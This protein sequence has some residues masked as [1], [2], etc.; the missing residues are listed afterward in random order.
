MV[1]LLSIYILTVDSHI[2]HCSLSWQHY[3]HV[4]TY[5]N[6]EIGRAEGAAKPSS[7]SM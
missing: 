5:S 1:L 7:Q 4:F 3:K 2:S 6:S